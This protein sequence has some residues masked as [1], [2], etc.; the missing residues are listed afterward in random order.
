MEATRPTAKAVSARNTTIKKYLKMVGKPWVIAGILGLIYAVVAIQ[1]QMASNTHKDLEARVAEARA[2]L[3]SPDVDIDALSLKLEGA[4]GSLEQTKTDL[5]R[6]VMDTEAGQQIQEV[7]RSTGVSIAGFQ[8]LLATQ[9]E[10]EANTYRV[11]QFTVRAQG[12]L[13]DLVAFTRRLESGAVPGLQVQQSNVR[14]VAS[15]VRD[16]TLQVVFYSL[17]PDAAPP[18]GAGQK[19]PSGAGSKK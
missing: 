16:L 11:T 17:I 2:G 6:T 3:A 14:N 7:A 12:E 5:A 15:A 9:V 4:K 8:S 1:Y 13:A 10:R 19:A 18:A